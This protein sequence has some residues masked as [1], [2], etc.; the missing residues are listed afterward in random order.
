MV[1]LQCSSS[2]CLVVTHP[3]KEGPTPDP[4]WCSCTKTSISLLRS[5]SDIIMR[6]ILPII[7]ILPNRKLRLSGK[8]ELVQAP[9]ARK[10]GSQHSYVSLSSSKALWILHMRVSP[11]RKAARLVLPG[12]QVKTEILRQ[13]VHCV[14]SLADG[15]KTESKWR[16]AWPT[17]QGD[18]SSLKS[19]QPRCGECSTNNFTSA[20]AGEKSSADEGSGRQL[21]AQQKAI[22]QMIA[23]WELTETAQQ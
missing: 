17:V 11:E 5:H 2:R 16:T 3:Q 22:N 15:W 10:Q 13:R 14:F 9:L 21:L 18:Q 1:S 8:K 6:A 12:K 19:C 4:S 20:P 23:T 7:S